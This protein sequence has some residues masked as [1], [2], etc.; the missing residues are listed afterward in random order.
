MSIWRLIVSCLI[1]H[2]HIFFR[3]QKTGLESLARVS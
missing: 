3:R 2:S 1:D